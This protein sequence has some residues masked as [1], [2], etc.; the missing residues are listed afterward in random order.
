MRKA[1]LA[2]AVLAGLV[3]AC[4]QQISAPPVPEPG[5][6][7][8]FPA[9]RYL[10]A[11]ARSEGIFR[12]D[13][14]LSL[15]VVTVRRDGPLAR[16]GHDHVVSSH[17]LGGYVSVDEGQA[18]LYVPLE[19]LAVDE[20]AL[21]A[22]E[23]LD[24]QPSN[25]DIVG[26]RSNMLERVLEVERYPFALVHVVRSTANATA[27]PLDVAIT[28]HD[29]TRTVQVPAQ[30]DFGVDQITASGRLE[31]DQSEFGIAPFSVLGGALRVQDRVNLRFRILA[32]RIERK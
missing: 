14:A 21:R 28:L 5:A 20:S 31:L 23:M 7:A 10:E 6:P 22:E 4:V 15:V 32:R 19:R 1:R 12:V 25:A 11:A 2:L 8:N 24:T 9:L 27:V 16:F 3:A 17:D 30:V 13:P 29:V 26:T 18:D